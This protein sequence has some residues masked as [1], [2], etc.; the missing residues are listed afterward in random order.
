MVVVTPSIPSGVLQVRSSELAEF[1]SYAQVVS[2]LMPFRLCWQPFT[3]PS[4]LQLEDAV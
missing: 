1:S 4:V 3:R 2:V